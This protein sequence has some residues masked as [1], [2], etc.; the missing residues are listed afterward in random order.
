MIVLKRGPDVHGPQTTNPDD[1]M[2]FNVVPQP[3]Q[4]TPHGRYANISI[5]CSLILANLNDYMQHNVPTC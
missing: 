1:H 2:M 4:V 5:L 3:Q